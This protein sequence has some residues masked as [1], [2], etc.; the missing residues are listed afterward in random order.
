M[1]WKIASVVGIG[2]L[3]LSVPLLVPYWEE[4]RL[5]R[6]A[7]ARYELSPVYDRNDASFYGHRISLKDAA[8]DRIAIEI[9]GKNYSDPAPAEIRD[10]FTDANRYHG[11][12]H[13]V[14][15]TDRKTGEERFA[16]VQRV[17]GVRTEQVTR[18]EGLR[19]RLLLVDRDGRVAEETFGYGEH[20]EP[21][22]RTMLA[23]YATPIAFGRSGAPYGYPPLLSWLLVPL[24][25]AAIGAVLA[26]AGI[27]GTFATHRRRKR[28]AG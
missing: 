18:V 27:V 7:Y 25:A 9:D 17:D 11:Y 13:L 12:A 14:R 2:L 26:V 1:R 16:V 22:Y 21:A 4:T 8:K 20:A 23:G 10:G 24:T 5:N 28:T 3:I 6:A 19:W 15:L